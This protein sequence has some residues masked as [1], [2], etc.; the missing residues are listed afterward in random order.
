MAWL[1]KAP[2]IPDPRGKAKGHDGAEISIR[3]PEAE[4]ELR[5]I[6]EID[7]TQRGSIPRG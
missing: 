2:P 1:I 6:V 5:N 3:K 4:R 7:V